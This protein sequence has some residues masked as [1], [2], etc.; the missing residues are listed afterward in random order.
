[1]AFARMDHHSP[2]RPDELGRWFIFSIGGHGALLALL[3]IKSLI[4]PSDTIMHT[5]T[6]RVDMVGLP[7]ILKKDLMKIPKTMPADLPQ[8]APAK[9]VPP[10]VVVAPEEAAT[11]DEMVLHPK[12]AS[13]TKAEKKQREKKISNALARIRALEKVSEEDAKDER[14]EADAVIVKGNKISKGTSLTADAKESMESSYFDL[15]RDAL[16]ENWALPPWLARQNLAA[17]VQIKIGSGGQITFIR[18]VKNSGSTA[19]D[20]AVKNT[21]RASQPLP[22]PPAAIVGNVG[23]AGILIGFPL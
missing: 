23:D 3:A 11:P 14:A 5:P 21:L 8:P 17:K 19:F 15:V 13:V 2:D 6:L 16:V 10:A 18:F 9:K 22:V 1:M 7:D 12:K 20:E 4:Y